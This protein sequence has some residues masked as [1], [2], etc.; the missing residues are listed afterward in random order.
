M[1]DY[2]HETG[3]NNPLGILGKQIIGN[4]NCQSAFNQIYK[5]YADAC[6]RTYFTEGI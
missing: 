5:G 3:Q 2:G 4:R 1:P 6:P